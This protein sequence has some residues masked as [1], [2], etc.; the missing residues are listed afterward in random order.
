MGAG[1][2]LS[3]GVLSST[4]SAGTS[5]KAYQV[6][7]RDSS[8]SQTINTTA[9][10]NLT[11]CS[12]T[13][14]SNGTGSVIVFHVQHMI[15]PLIAQPNNLGDWRL[16][17]TKTGSTTQYIPNSSGVGLVSPYAA[18]DLSSMGGSFIISGLAAGSWTVTLQMKVDSGHGIQAQTSNSSATC[19]VM[20]LGQ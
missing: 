10:T 2:S 9:W 16:Q 20:V 19:T 4:V 15:G 1:L 7:T 5:V 12:G 18:D 13:F 8:S 17:L 3:G 11:G 6:Y 14:V